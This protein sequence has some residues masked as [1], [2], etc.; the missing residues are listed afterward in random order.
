MRRSL[1]LVGASL[2][3]L[4]AAAPALAQAP[5]AAG[6]PEDGDVSEVVVTAAPF[7]ISE[8]SATTSVAIV[9]RDALD[10]APAGGLG[11]LL[12]GLP[13][14]RSTSFGPGA[15]RPVVRGLAGPRVS[16]LTNGVGLIDAS[17]LS[18][19]HQVAS[20]PG[21]AE[22]VEVLRGPAALLYGGSAIGGVV[23][24]FD[25]RIARSLPDRA[26]S[27][28]FN[29]SA[30]SVDDGH[31]LSGA[32]RFTTGPIVFS[33]DALSRESGDYEIPAYPESRQQLDAEG[34]DPEKPF[35]KRLENSAVKLDTFGLGVSF[36]GDEGYFGLAV[37][38]VDTRYGVP[39]HAHEEPAVP[40][41]V[42]VEEDPVTIGLMQTRLDVRAERHVAFGP[43][44]TVRFSGGYA[45]YTHTEYEG[46]ETGTVFMSDGLEGRLELVQIERGGWNGAVGVQA[47]R[48]DFDAAGDEAYVPRTR[49]D[50]LGVFT[51]Q[52][53]DLGG[54]GYEGGLRFDRRT[55]DSLAGQREF[56]NVSGSAGLF[57]R[58]ADNWFLGAS[59]SRTGRAPTEAE[60][61]ADGPHVATRGYEVGDA[62]LT[63]EVATSLELTAHYG[64]DRLSADLHLYAVRY[65]GFIDLMP[66]GLEIDDLQV[67]NY[68]Q[69]DADFQGL[70]AEASWT[71]WSDGGRKLSLEFGA[72]Y[73]RA[74]TDLG[75]PA[76]IPPWSLTSRLVWEGPQWTGRLE[77]RHVAEQDRVATFELP[78]D[79]YTQVNL[80][81]SWSPPALKGAK[82]YAEIRNVT[83]EEIR[84]HV[85]YLKDLAPQP[86]RNVRA[87]IAWRF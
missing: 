26:L 68:V 39:G 35:P 71:A 18:P 48:R 41:P 80:S 55:L 3:T 87:G 51:L 45:D 17:A 77:V 63:E 36:V 44:Q 53:V 10:Q 2:L 8:D 42:P 76:R 21:E 85:S 61:F 1:A 38:S 24:I 62:D 66:T 47:L 70:E 57:V 86:G 83:D 23:N 65:D 30:S 82:L 59:L 19:D 64:G 28:R 33:F 7:A 79:S 9:D 69:T 72:D 13:G 75:T 11:D 16:V 31:S 52:R 20:D 56:D 73:V 22:R 34:E 5:Q 43:F 78:T 29:A 25:D 4:A 54:W 6:S 37:K 58:P 50:E 67:F 49:I 81:G 32:L 15:S 27:G 12:G 46:A 84:E 74:S 14:L 40:P 60:L